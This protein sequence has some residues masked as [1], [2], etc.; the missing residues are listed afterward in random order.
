[1][2]PQVAIVVNGR[3]ISRDEYLAALQGEYDAFAAHTGFQASDIAEVTSYLNDKVRDQLINRILVQQAALSLGIAITQEQLNAEIASLRGTDEQ[4]FQAW[5][6]DNQLT[7]SQLTA[8]YADQMLALAVRDAVTKDTAREQPHRHVRYLVTSSL[9]QAQLAREALNAGSDFAEVTRQYSSDISL[10]A[11]G[12]DVGFIPR[13]ILPE[14]ADQA[15][16]TLAEDAISDVVLT[17]S[18][19]YIV[20]VLE[21]DISRPVSEDYW[22]FVLQ[23]AF[24]SWLANERSQA[25]IAIN[26]V[27]E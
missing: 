14:A 12:G 13:G 5:L 23:N 10:H 21:I 27:V 20:Q 11:S 25:E 6:Q 19:F 7:E 4:E 18:G 26:P 2:D 16:F 3:T 15:A 17:A 9:E 1:M 24:Q 8:Q 22:P